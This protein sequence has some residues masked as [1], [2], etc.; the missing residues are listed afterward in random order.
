[1]T[2]SYQLKYSELKP[3]V[4]NLAERERKAVTLVRVCQDFLQRQDLSHL[5]VLDVGSSSGIIDNFLADHFG[6]VTGIDI[7]APAM[8]W[9]QANFDKPNLHYA[10]GDAMQLA[11]A[12]EQFDVVVCSHVYEHVPDA[13]TMFDEIH[14]VLKPG[15]F[16]YFSG[17]NRVMWM[18]PHYRLPLLSVLPRP[19]AHRYMRLAGKG[20][21]YHEQHLSYRA[22]KALC[23]S[24][25]LHDYSR[26]I[27]Q[28]P[29]R[30][31]ADYMLT[32]GSLKWRLAKTVARR[33][34]WATPHIW[35]LQKPGD[36]AA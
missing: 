26:A 25:Q 32:P 28:D 36:T 21:Y 15:G 11:F 8:A 2:R 35:L 31:G 5:S 34:P 30:F 18:E 16:C 14:R 6:S 19:L 24:F 12:S 10:Q 20:E 33:A 13:R 3:S 29:A 9:A 7:D 22:L 17:N 4:F 23:S 1:M 27:I